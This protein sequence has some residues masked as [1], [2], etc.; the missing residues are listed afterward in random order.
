MNTHPTIMVYA[1]LDPAVMD[2]FETW[3][4]E[5]HLPH[6]LAIPGVVRARRVRSRDE[7]PGS[8]QLEIELEDE[9]SIQRVMGSPQAQAARQDW[10][11]WAGHVHEL[12]V[13][14]LAPLQPSL[15]V[16]AKN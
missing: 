2:R 8:H 9:G 16:Y 14:V 10:N 1:R 11:T 13:E 7:V 5:T 15:P 12:R 4:A 3:H 6:V